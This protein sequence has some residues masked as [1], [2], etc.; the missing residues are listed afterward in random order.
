MRFGG[1]DRKM[2]INADQD[3]MTQISPFKTPPAKAFKLRKP[4][5]S[6]FADVTGKYI[7]MHDGVNKTGDICLHRNGDVTHEVGWTGGR[8]FTLPDGKLCIHFNNI[9]HIMVPTSDYKHLILIE[10]D[11]FPASVATFVE[12]LKVQNETEQDTDEILGEWNWR[13]DGVNRQGD[14]IFGPNGKLSSSVW[15][16]TDR[17]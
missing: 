16:G 9:K 7:W 4:S 14:L 10:P 5:D 12:R 17:W 3:T 6:C 1:T 2:I 15:E 13:H 8:W 11:R